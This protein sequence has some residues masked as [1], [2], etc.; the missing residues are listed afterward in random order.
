MQQNFLPA[1]NDLLSSYKDTAMKRVRAHGEDRLLF[2]S[3]T[4]CV[5]GVQAYCCAGQQTPGYGAYPGRGLLASVGEGEYLQGKSTR[6]CCT[7]VFA[8]LATAA[9]KAALV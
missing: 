6:S 3:I 2:W 8:E 7:R 4:F 5:L 1:T 9:R